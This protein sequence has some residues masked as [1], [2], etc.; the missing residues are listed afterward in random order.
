MS[1]DDR[2]A[3][4]ALPEWHLPALAATDA[5]TAFAIGLHHLAESDRFAKFW[6][7]E[8]HILV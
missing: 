3:E 2:G 6:E 5:Q 4:G 7:F 8:R 1:K